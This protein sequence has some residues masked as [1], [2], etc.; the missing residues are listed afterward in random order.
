M[1]VALCAAGDY[2]F[3]SFGGGWASR[4]T[5]SKN[6][7]SEVAKDPGNLQKPR[8]GEVEKNALSSPFS[9]LTF[10]VLLAWPDTGVSEKIFA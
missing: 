8:Y 1:S 3:D 7:I 4:E 10:L 2:D 9:D 6:N 5:P